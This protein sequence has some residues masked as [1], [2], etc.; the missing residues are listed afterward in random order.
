MPAW[1]FMA[2]L[3][4]AVALPAHAAE[5]V[6]PPLPPE[7]GEVAIL[8][9]DD[10]GQVVN[11]VLVTPWPE[12]PPD[13]YVLRYFPGL[14][15][16]QGQAPVRPSEA[17]AP[18]AAGFEAPALGVGLEGRSPRG[19]GWQLLANWSSSPLAPAPDPRLVLHGFWLPHHR[20]GFDADVGLDPRGSTTAEL[21]TSLLL[22][23]DGRMDQRL[24]V[25]A[26]RQEGSGVPGYGYGQASFTRDFAGLG[27]TAGLSGFLGQD[28]ASLGG[29]DAWHTW[30]PMPDLRCATTGSIGLGDPRLPAGRR[31]GVGLVASGP[32]TADARAAART[33]IAVP[34]ARRIGWGWA[35]VA[36]LAQVEGAVFVEGAIARGTSDGRDGARTGVGCQLD[37]TAD[38]ALGMPFT[39]GIGVAVPVTGADGAPRVY[40]GTS[41][42]RFGR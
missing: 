38:T 9:R 36:T 7:P 42:V 41:G 19:H 16:R 10:A 23:P 37:F 8:V 15:F 25:G 24:R 17:A 31:L 39:L 34:L 13:A 32:A 28:G 22:G 5:Q 40:V 12:A 29:L 4:L 1:L 21:G 3:A 27:L 35:P 6:G 11:K 26:G 30:L 33:E 2:F 20:W 14:T 18:I